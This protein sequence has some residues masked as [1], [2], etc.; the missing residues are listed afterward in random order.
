MK[1]MLINATQ[2]E[3]LRVAMV[4]GQKLYDLDIETPTREQKKANV[5]KGRITRIEPSLEAAFVDYGA[6]RHGFLP[7]KEITRNYF[8]PHASGGGRPSIKEALKEG[9]EVLVQVDKEE[10]GT[11]GAALTTYISLAGRY[12]VLMPNNPRAGGVSRRIEGDDRQEIRETMNNLDIPEGMGLIVRTAGVGRS[13]DELQWDLDYLLH[14]WRA[15]ETAS[16]EKKAPFLVYQESNI[17]IRA[18]RDYLRVDIGEI[19]VDDPAVYQTARDFVQQVMPNYLSKLKLYRDHTPLFTRFQIESQIETAYQREVALPSGGAIVIDYT[20]ALVSIDINSARATKGSD[21]EET[22][23]S[24]NL[25]A[26]DEIARQLRLRDLGGLIVIDFI[27]MSLSR[28]QREVENRLREA[29][30]MDRARVQLGRISR[31]GLLEM[32][33][34][35]LRPSLDEAS[36]MLCPRCD[37]QGTIRNVESLALAVLRLVEEEAIKDRTAQVVAQLPLKVATFLLNEK[38][39]SIHIIEQRHRVKVIVIPNAFM[40][41]P[42]FKVMRRRVDEVTD[43]QEISYTLVSDAEEEG[44]EQAVAPRVVSAEP[45]VKSIKP[46]SPVPPTPSAPGQAETH[47]GFLKWLWRNLFDHSEAVPAK[48]PE[49]QAS[50]RSPLTPADTEAPRPRRR[51]RRRRAPEPSEETAAALSSSE[52]EATLET[53]PSEVKE[54]TANHSAVASD[55]AEEVETGRSSRRGR[56]GGR[57]RRKPDTTVSDGVSPQ[58]D[59]TDREVDKE[60]DAVATDAV[61]TSAEESTA[62]APEVN[63]MPTRAIPPNRRVRSGRPRI[64]SKSILDADEQS[65]EARTLSDDTPVPEQPPIDRAD[66]DQVTATIRSATEA[67]ERPTAPAAAS[68]EMT[69]DPPQ[70][71]M[72][73]SDSQISVPEMPAFP[74]PLSPSSWEETEKVADIPSPA[75]PFFEEKLASTDDQVAAPV[76]VADAADMPESAASELAAVAEDKGNARDNNALVFLQSLTASAG[77]P[78]AEFPV[79]STGTVAQQVTRADETVMTEEISAQAAE[80]SVE[81]KS[82]VDPSQT[83]PQLTAGP[84]PTDRLTGKADDEQA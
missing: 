13:I 67:E 52:T 43:A 19:L 50:H 48:Q 62:A 40:E 78:A 58:T 6:D 44:L 64:P 49:Q 18:L 1:R 79:R 82:E 55:A 39:D 26:A 66:A 45:L 71:P 53:E 75:K 15:I 24:T 77:T 37:G 72:N 27:D 21:I 74:V 5:Y 29:L 23:L 80:G 3:E 14:L 25:E 69:S 65:D 32:S 83:V 12:L 56:R 22:A 42:K 38:R 60:A 84:F 33:R 76:A 51:S 8:D 28:N 68:E 81:K 7:F 47:F 41:T 35:R 10:R 20:E 73:A 2:Q 31:F 54:A 17:I 59:V 57:R 30:K 70:A 4:E 46:T 9:Q 63:R 34:Q 16:Q 36:H 11:K 61:A